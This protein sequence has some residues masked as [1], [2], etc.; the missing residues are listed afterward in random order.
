M[1]SNV[2]N[3]WKKS[4]ENRRSLTFKLDKKNFDS[5]VPDFPR[6]LVLDINNRCNHKCYFCANP[7]IEKYDSLDFDLALKLMKEARSLGATDLGLQATGEPFMDKRL[8]QFVLA[9]K[10]IG[11]SYIY[12]NS[13]GALASPEKVKP[14]IDAGCDSIKFS[15]NAHNREDFKSV[16]GYDDFD[17]VISNLKWIFNYRNEKKVKMGIYVSSVSNS[18]TEITKDV[19]NTITDHCDNFS[20][21]EVSNQGGSMME[22]NNTEEIINGNILGSL[23]KSEYTSRCVYPFNRVVVNP[24]GSVIPCT[25]DFHNMLEIG[26]AKSNSL[27]DIWKSDPFKYLRKKHLTDDYEGIFCDK[28]LNNKVCKSEK[29]VN[30]F[31]KKL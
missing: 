28:C 27:I 24:Y 10:K 14:V 26:D 20:I 29:L 11:Y 3:Y 17:K 8:A 23:E 16:H 19:K 1:K 7:K 2:S 6:E 13:N 31:E 15:I 12:I 4:L 5:E 22:L 9:G 21:R 18:K 25:A 30:A